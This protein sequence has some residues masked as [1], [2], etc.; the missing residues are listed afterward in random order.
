MSVSEDFSDYVRD[1][2]SGVGDLR[3]KRMFGGV[4]I[5]S[6]ERFF[7]LIADDVLYFKVDDGNREGFTA[8]GMAPFSY[9]RKDGKTMR[10]PSFYPLPADILEDTEALSDWAGGALAAAERAA[11]G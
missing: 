8:R 10:M 1:Q 4:G 5:Y 9:Q 7:A 2:L 11:S 6:G 3:M